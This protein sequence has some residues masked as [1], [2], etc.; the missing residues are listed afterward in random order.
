M[1]E[2]QRIMLLRNLRIEKENVYRLIQSFNEESYSRFKK[3]LDNE[4]SKKPISLL[5]SH[6]MDFFPCEHEYGVKN[7]MDS[8]NCKRCMCLDCGEYLKDTEVKKVLCANDSLEEIRNAY[9]ELLF[10]NSVSD[11]FVSLKRKYSLK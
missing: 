9:L 8:F 3:A 11:S 7:E 6:I 1:K 4:Y 2:I 5:D 10:D